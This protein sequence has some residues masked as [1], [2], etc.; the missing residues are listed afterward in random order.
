[1][2]GSVERLR[3]GRRAQRAVDPLRLPLDVVAALA[4]RLRHGAQ[5]LREARDPVARLGREVRAGVERL[6]VGRH[7]DRRRP[8]AGA[9]HPDRRLHRHRVDVGPLLAVDLDVHEELVHER[10]RRLALERLVRHDVAPVA[11]AVADRDE[12]RLVLGPGALERLVAPLVP[13]DRVLGVLE[14]VRRR[15]RREP[16]HAARRLATGAAQA[17]SCGPGARRAAL[18]CTCL[19]A[20]TTK[21]S[22]SAIPRAMRSP[23]H[24]WSSN[25]FPPK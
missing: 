5:H 15:R 19:T 8:A 16:V 7:E 4:P 14:E 2:S 17:A 13:V 24:G 18:R 23:N 3:A 1:M 9:G 22:E 6:A 20:S 12:E 10:G 25:V 11:R 21:P